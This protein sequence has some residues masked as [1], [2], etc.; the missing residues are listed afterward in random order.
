MPAGLA[1]G[2]IVSNV[3]NCFVTILLGTLFGIIPLVSTVT[4]GMTLGWFAGVALQKSC[5]C[6]IM[7]GGLPRGLF[8]IPAILLS[9]AIGLKLGYSLVMSLAGKKGLID[10]IKKSVRAFV[11][12]ILPGIVIAALLETFF[13]YPLLACISSGI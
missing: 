2:I 3:I 10:E 13:T 8:E 4:N 9:S 11:F 1:I 12:W 6:Y 7:A 5:L